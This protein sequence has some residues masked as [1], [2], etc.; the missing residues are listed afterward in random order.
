[1]HCALN[2]M[3]ISCSSPNCISSSKSRR[4]MF[5]SCLTHN[6]KAIAYAVIIRATGFYNGKSIGAAN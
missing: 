4:L 6:L 5:D 2:N 3:L 1:M